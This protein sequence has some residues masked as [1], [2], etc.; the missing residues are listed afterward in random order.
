MGPFDEN[1]QAK[2]ARAIES[3]LSNPKLGK[4]TRDIWTSHLRNLAV[5]EDEYNKRVREVYSNYKPMLISRA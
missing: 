3:V 4:Y 5:T 1:V 2:R